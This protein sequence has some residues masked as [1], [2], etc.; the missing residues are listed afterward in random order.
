M[1]TFATFFERVAGLSRATHLVCGVPCAMAPCDSEFEI[2][3][4]AR[5]GA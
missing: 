3:D 4:Y 5:E 2:D 1:E